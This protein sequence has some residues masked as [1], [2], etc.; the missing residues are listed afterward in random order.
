MYMKAEEGLKAIADIER[1]LDVV[2]SVTPSEARNMG[3]AFTNF[4]ELAYRGLT[5]QYRRSDDSVLP[6]RPLDL[7]VKAGE[8]IFLVGGNGSGKSTTLR[9][10][11][12]LYPADERRHRGRWHSCRGTRRCW[13]SRAVLGRLCRFPSLRSPVRPRGCRTRAEVQRLISEMGLAHKVSFEN[14]QFSQTS[15]SRAGA[16]VWR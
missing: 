4:R 1:K 13:D 11:T 12:G 14:G 3:R 2:G 8:T 16:N 15:L 5:F 10:M 7:T 6:R 9:L